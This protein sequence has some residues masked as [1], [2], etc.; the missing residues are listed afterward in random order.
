MLSLG[1][2]NS[3]PLPTNPPNPSGTFSFLVNNQS[4]TYPGW[5]DAEGIV[6]S[7]EDVYGTD[8]IN[9]INGAR[10]NSILT[11]SQKGNSN[12][13]A[14]YKVSTTWTQNFLLIQGY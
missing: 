2:A 7:N 13:F 5:N 3:T 8:I 6:L 1:E 14:H 10:P 11:V 4:I 12:N 9:W